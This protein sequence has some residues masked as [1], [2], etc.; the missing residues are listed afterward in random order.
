M[1]KVLKGLSKVKKA[2]DEIKEGT[3]KLFADKF[4]SQLDEGQAPSRGT[5]DVEEGRAGTVTRGDLSE[6]RMQE[7]ASA[8]SRARAEL[9]S[10]LETKEEKGTIT[11]KEK[12]LLDNLNAMSEE[13]DI[14]RTRKAA[15]TRSSDARK[16]E[17]VSL[18]TEE[19]PKRVGS[20]PKLKDSDMLIGN[21]DN[22]ITKDGEIV[23]NPTDN[24]IQAVV[25][26]MEAR[27]RLSK[28]A[29]ENLV[30]L[31]QLSQTQKQDKAISIMERNMIDTGPDQ[32][33]GIMGR[34]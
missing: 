3:Q 4:V 8:G 16:S 32:T 1:V 25:R 24:Q 20:K 15:V 30:K 17:G 19:G 11:K 14:S 18:M 21:T 28:D 2:T 23:G 10:I 7:S 31:K 34:P 22:G 9:V 29:K 12:E 13:A 26:N 5:L 6:P 33:G 27:E